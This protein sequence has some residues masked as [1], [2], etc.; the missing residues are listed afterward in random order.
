MN[1][2][3]ISAVL[4]V[5][6]IFAIPFA[7]LGAGQVEWTP[8]GK[9]VD[10][11]LRTY[12]YGRPAVI[13]DG[14]GG[15][16][17]AWA[18]QNAGY[19]IYAQRLDENGNPLWDENGVLICT[20]NSNQQDPMM[21]SDGSGGA[22]IT[23]NDQ[24]NY[25]IYAQRVDS[26]GQVKWTANGVVICDAAGDKEDPRLVSDGSGGAII[27][28]TDGR[29]S[30]TEIYAQ[31]VDT[32]GAV[33]WT[34][35]GVNVSDDG[36]VYDNESPTLVSDGSGGAIIAWTADG[37]DTNNR[38]AAQRLDENGS[39]QWS[40]AAVI[41]AV[42]NG[43]GD[44]VS[45]TDGSGGA[46]ISWPDS[47]NY[48]STQY[49]I[50]AQRVNGSGVVQWTA[51][52]VVIC[53]AADWQQVPRLVNDGSGG[54]IITW[55]D[56][57]SGTSED[58]YAQ[59]VDSGGQVKWD[60]NGVV[61]C[62]AAGHQLDPRLVSDGSGGAIITWDDQGTYDIY[63]Q[64]VNESGVMQWAPNGLVICD[65]AGK[66]KVP[67]L[68][69]SGLGGAII[70][71]TDER[72]DPSS[73]YADLYA[74]RAITSQQAPTVTT[75][76]VINP[77][78][79]T[80]TG[81]GNITDLGAP[82]PTAHGVCW[83][84]TGTPT[85]GDSKTDE[86]AASATGTFTSNM[87]GLAPNTKYY[88]RAY[89]ENSAGTVYGGEVNFTTSTQAPTVA[90]QA[91]TDPG[92]TTATGNGNITDLGAPN[93]TAH[94]V[95][96]NTTGTPTTG[97]SKTDE[98]AASATGT[99]TSNMTGLAPNT[100][101]YVRAYAENSAGT[102]YGGEVNFTTS[103]QAPT[104]ATQ[105]VTDPGATTATGN[106]NI[107]DLGAPN[108]T[109]HGV[110][111]NTTGTPTTGDSKTDEGAASATGTFTSNMTGLSPNTKYYVRAYAENSA[112]TV[113]GG[114]VSFTTSAQAPTVTT[115]AVTN[116]GAT[117]ATGNGNITDL[118]A[119]NPTAHGVCWN[120]TGT[121]TTGDSKTDEGA[122]SATGA[123]TSNMTGLSPNTKYYVRAYAEN[124]AGTV[125]GGEVSFTTSA[126]APTVTTQAVTNPG[127]T[128]ATGNG[129]I[130]DLGAPNP[131]AHG[132][133][134]NTTGTPTTGDSKTDEGAASAT[135]AFTSNMT[136]L[137]PNTKYYVRAYA[138]NS[139][140]TVYGGEVSFTTSAQGPTITDFDPKTG[141]PGTVV[142]ITG[143]NFT[144]T[145]VQFGGTHAESF[146][147]D[148]L[149]QITAVVGQGSSGKITVTTDEGTATSADDFIFQAQIPTLGEWGL[150][151]LA[152]LLGG[153]GITITRRQRVR[154]GLDN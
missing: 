46:I 76:A 137:S 45:A 13:S 127:A 64:R 23:W 148:S 47:R 143:T 77:G 53:D 103:T 40:D 96:W 113:Y 1:K 109:A 134:W 150:I 72:N 133:C 82:N 43:N 124:S 35:N 145:T 78:A 95:C 66:Q 154:A 118:G 29:T 62:A 41:C 24:E 136:G 74:Q 11:L 31:R 121:P 85:T 55:Q 112:G 97:D 21:V 141:G 73:F 146:T 59:R 71:W 111:W 142:V 27:T 10:E 58:I 83:N 104:V 106:G 36:V 9:P 91:V 56:Y 52:G 69:Q 110:C 114:E 65:A 15:V 42:Q 140:G 131:T 129:N 68:A 130:T 17:I 98:G 37:G 20:R 153:A 132:V 88:V 94:G 75:Q 44:V 128:T 7:A 144:G 152:L 116:P 12:E 49:D 123:F 28:W 81:N 126:Q 2:L 122:A 22:I 84:T 135:G 147:V 60:E 101:Y 39:R 30:P 61:I 6:S 119:P 54:A 120:T 151:M 102:V 18:A 19:D 138:E 32:N 25:H 149:T 115:Q 125:Y 48:A 57:R 70:A 93:P 117:T 108:P 86:G 90:T 80:A 3:K 26:G 63:A 5:I 51:N 107:T 8:N 105:A 33:K 67:N 99:F 89:A 100:K 79:T 87:T 34:S 14:S 16:I 50:Y 4:L 38:I 92:A 139:A